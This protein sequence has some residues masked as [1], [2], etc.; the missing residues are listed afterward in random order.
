MSIFKLGSVKLSHTEEEVPMFYVAIHITSSLGDT[1]PRM[2]TDVD[3][4]NRIYGDFPEFE[5]CSRLLDNGISLLVEPI[6][7]INSEYNKATLELGGD[8][9]RKSEDDYIKYGPRGYRYYHPTL[10]DYKRFFNLIGYS[11]SVEVE[12]QNLQVDE[13]TYALHFTDYDLS[14]NGNPSNRF[15]AIVPG[16]NGTYL[17]AYNSNVIYSNYYNHHYKNGEFI[18]SE[19]Q[20]RESLKSI[21]SSSIVLTS[22]EIISLLCNDVAQAYVDDGSLITPLEYIEDM[23]LTSVRTLLM[24]IVSAVIDYVANIYLPFDEAPQI[25]SGLISYLY[26]KEPKQS[27]TSL[28]F[29]DGSKVDINPYEVRWSE[30]DEMYKLTNSGK[31][32]NPIKDRLLSFP[33]TITSDDLY[34]FYKK[35]V[36]KVYSIFNDTETRKGKI[37]GVHSFDECV[38]QSFNE[39]RRC[40]RFKSKFKGDY[41]DRIF[42]DI[43]RVPNTDFRYSITFRNSQITESYLVCTD[44]SQVLDGYEQ[45]Y[46]RVRD[47]SSQ[48]QLVDTEEF[49]YLTPTR[50]VDKFL[51][52]LN[53]AYVPYTKVS[54]E[55][56]GEV[57]AYD[58]L[59]SGYDSYTYNLQGGYEEQDSIISRLIFLDNI[60]R[61][62]YHP[63]LVC[64]DSMLQ[65]WFNGTDIEFKEAYYEQ[66]WSM[67]QAQYSQALVDC[68][69]DWTDQFENTTNP[70]DQ[71]FQNDRLYNLFKQ[72]KE[73]RLCL[74]RGTITLDNVTFPGYYPFIINFVS[75]AYLNVI[76][77]EI[78]SHIKE[79]DLDEYFEELTEAKRKVLIRRHIN[80]IDY[81]NLRYF[82]SNIREIYVDPNFIIRFC[83]SKLS[84]ICLEQAR[85]IN[86]NP[87]TVDSSIKNAIEIYNYYVTLYTNL[88]YSYTLNDHLLTITFVTTFP[89]IVNKQYTI[90]LTLNY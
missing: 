65:G 37:V 17:L 58:L 13:L 44:L 82:Y 31:V 47:I 42:V 51:E 23:D 88:E 5:F 20:V 35:P 66:L 83:I 7:T 90:N 45:G 89:E 62:D 25:L 33:S 27:D 86:I 10:K 81:D 74:F 71:E 56:S 16:A 46:I 63:D 26:I 75:G 22:K 54:G 21:D 30:L 68:S 41:Q 29:L 34:V 69:E 9:Y 76:S 49:D 24:Q 64:D 57:C 12:H 87:K 14:E 1:K 48:S 59:P 61:Y 36:A 15:Y 80:F 18:G 72:F 3:T 19:G 52:D 39:R 85:L 2:I 70:R 77:D 84:R 78:I 28:R 38:C 73:S 4:L 8:I 67:C 40:V 53:E 50:K 11:P 43:E 6:Q 55:V 32:S 79:K 60:V